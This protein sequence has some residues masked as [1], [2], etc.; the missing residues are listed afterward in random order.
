MKGFNTVARQKRKA[1]N[2]TS[3]TSH[4]LFPAVVALWFGALFG[5]GSLAVRPTLLESLVLK[6]KIDLLIPAA[7]PPLGVTARLLVALGLAAFGAMLGAIIARRLARPR[8]VERTRKRAN[9]ST[10]DEGMQVRSRDAHPDAPARR[11]ISVTEELGA[12]GMSPAAPGVLAARRRALAIEEEKGEFMPSEFAPLP[13]GQPQVFDIASMQQDPAFEH[14][15]ADGSLAGGTFAQPEAEIAQQPASVALDWSNA[16]PVATIAPQPAAPLVQVPQAIAQQ[17]QVFQEL[18]SAEPTPEPAP[19]PAP[20]PDADGRQVFGMAPPAQPAI[21]KPRQIFGEAIAGDHVPKEFVEAHGFKTSVFDTPEPSPL[22]PTREASPELG[23][24][25]TGQ[26]AI[27]PAPIQPAAGES[28][29]AI[30]QAFDPA[31]YSA[32]VAAPEL[33]SPI[34]PA[35]APEPIV[36]QAP[37][38]AEAAQSSPDALDMDGLAARLAES[39]RRRRA[40]R[41]EV[42]VGVESNSLLQAPEPAAFAAEPVEAAQPVISPQ[43]EPFAPSVFEASAPAA[44][45]PAP[46]VP[47]AFEPQPIPAPEMPAAIEP[48][49]LAAPTVVMPSAMR[50]LELGGFEAEDTDQADSLLPPRWIGQAQPVPMA[51]APAIA[52]PVQAEAPVVPTA[53]VPEPVEEPVE[54]EPVEAIPEESYG[55]LLGIAPAA[56]RNPFVRIEEAEPDAGTVEPVVIF[57][58]QAPLASVPPAA[59]NDASFRQ[60]DAPGNAGAGQPI[61]ASDSGPAVAPD[62]AERVLRAALSN[63]QRMSGAA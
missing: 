58:G 17:R 20:I 53:Y 52:A 47:V 49:P 33:P 41:G 6:T 23:D 11:P 44:F 62:E 7:A 9:L 42:A 25:N 15:A 4:Q 38:M 46:A 19:T 22:F 28:P 14:P 36:A 48:Q 50:P 10:R 43:P 37:I 2:R 59:N 13:G 55:S 12:D 29:F 60:F 16:A 21:E 24:E 31:A 61:A 27:A 45:D 35:P 18:P 5:L 51:P 56:P 32:P 3:I 8:P 63:L 30:P 1:S 39:M 54:A 57:P 34:E 40:A 26:A